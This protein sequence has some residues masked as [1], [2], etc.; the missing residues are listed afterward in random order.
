[1]SDYNCILCD[2]V[3]HLTFCIFYAVFCRFFRQFTVHCEFFF[4]RSLRQFDIEGCKR[5]V[6]PYLHQVMT[7]CSDSSALRLTLFIVYLIIQL[8]SSHPF[9]IDKRSNMT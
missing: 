7:V 9:G 3:D 5:T 2:E 6:L 1:M 4:H 8:D